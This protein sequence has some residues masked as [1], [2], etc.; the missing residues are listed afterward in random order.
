MN[1]SINNIAEDHYMGLS[2]SELR[3]Q[4]V[5]SEAKLSELKNYLMGRL[6]VVGNMKKQL[7]ADKD[8]FVKDTFNSELIRLNVVREEL[9]TILYM[10]GGTK[11]LSALSDE[12]L[13]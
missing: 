12:G 7:I 5:K 2:E 3:L 10:I 11:E 4:S 13:I 6:I 9:I 1:D 8:M